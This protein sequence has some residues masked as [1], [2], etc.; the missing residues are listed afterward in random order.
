[1]PPGTA[2]SA[3]DAMLISID[4]VQLGI[5]TGG[6]ATALAFVVGDLTETRDRLTAA[7]I[8]IV[9]DDSGL[10]ARRCYVRPALRAGRASAG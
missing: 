6:E 8:A 7:G 10:P 5:P 4:H 2:S 9:E 3:L 1:M